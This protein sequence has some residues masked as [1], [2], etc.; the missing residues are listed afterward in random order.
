VRRI[1]C[2]GIPAAFRTLSEQFQPRNFETVVDG[3]NIIAVQPATRNL[4]EFGLGGGRRFRVPIL[5]QK[6]EARIAALVGTPLVTSARA[7]GRLFGKPLQRI[8]PESVQATRLLKGLTRARLARKGKEFSKVQ[9]ESILKGVVDNII[10][11]G[12]PPDEIADTIREQFFTDITN[13]R[14]LGTARVQQIYGD[15]AANFVEDLN[16]MV[17]QATD[18][19]IARGARNDSL[20][21]DY[22]ERILTP[23][24]RLALRK[25]G[26]TAAFRSFL[27]DQANLWEN[28]Q[29]KRRDYTRDALNTDAERFFR[30]QLGLVDEKVEFID[31]NKIDPL[32][33]ED[34]GANLNQ[35]FVFLEDS[36]KGEKGRLRDNELAEGLFE[37]K[38]GMALDDLSLGAAYMKH[39]VEDQGMDFTKA[40]ARIRKLGEG[41]GLFDESRDLSNLVAGLQN[42]LPAE[43]GE[44]FFNLNPAETVARTVRER[45]MTVINA[46]LAQSF[47]RDMMGIPGRAGDMPVA[48]F[49]KAIGLR[50]LGNTKFAAN[51]LGAIG[52]SLENAGI[53]AGSTIPAEAAAEFIKVYGKFEKLNPSQLRKFVEEVWDP[54]TSV[55]RIGVTAPLPFLAFHVRN[56]SSNVMLNYMGGVKGLKYYKRA[57][58][59]FFRTN[60]PAANWLSQKGIKVKFDPR[61][62]EQWTGIGLIKGGQLGQITESA[63]QE[64]L[65]GGL[66]RPVGGGILESA[67]FASSAALNFARKNPLS[68][69][70]FALGTFVEDMSRIAHFLAKKDKG[71]T[72]AGAVAE[73]NKFLFDYSNEALNGMEKGLLNRLFFFYRWNRFALPLVV[74][75]FLE[76]PR[77][78]AIL[79]KTT[80]QPG[81][82]RPAGI[83][84]FIREAAGIPAGPVDPETG[85]QPFVS[86]FGSP[87]EVL[88]AV[89]PTVSDDDL[90]F[91][92]T[93]KKV[94]REFIQQSVPM[95][96]ASTEFLSGQDLFLGRDLPEL[97]K[98]GSLQALLGEG[99]SAAGLPSVGRAIGE[100][101]PRPQR[102]GERFRTDPDIRF[103]LRNLP[104]SRLT[105]TTSRLA[106]LLGN[107]PEKV[108]LPGVSPTDIGERLGLFKQDVERSG[109]KSTAEELLRTVLGVSLADVN[110]AEEAKR[111]AQRVVGS[112]LKEAQVRGEVGRLPIFIPTEKTRQ[113]A[114]PR[115]RDLLDEFRR[116]S[117]AV[118]R[119]PRPQPI[120]RQRLG[121]VR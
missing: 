68:K 94:A 29:F 115:I 23:A 96:R 5:P 52:R 76:D 46:E 99:I 82:E 121:S 77:R 6:L 27:I 60:E 63:A 54:M 95:I 97:D 17:D 41:G 80:T 43:V 113:A 98:A 120:Q 33:A 22:A 104:T 90:G 2:K 72:N 102:R 18:S 48:N 71:F 112:E 67:A 111:R 44:K 51:D 42:L 101:V 110:I 8:I 57:I 13:A 75:T 25:S 108:G 3:K 109:E 105:Q 78:A 34:F 49:I 86:R 73:V 119:T 1:C 36:L 85:E 21:L 74:N 50:R 58:Q 106:E 84:E 59:E 70:G 61:K 53:D 35:A 107:L 83:P 66:N 56:F 19:Q 15:E 16:K 39:L 118:P 38:S 64:A 93:T 91:L 24:G 103:I 117:E 65:R 26:K 4:L 9:E 32:L 88:G 11:T 47:I 28:S 81:I 14:Q 116:I 7:A 30:E 12:N 89:D 92:S 100:E 62:A 10:A 114:D 55:F 37:I 79:L 45:S 87:F 69:K 31:L 40:I 20:L